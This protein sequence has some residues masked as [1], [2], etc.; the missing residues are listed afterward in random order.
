VAEHVFT[1]GEIHCDGCEN[2]IRTSLGRLSGVRDVRPDQATNTV[3]IRYDA[4]QVD[5]DQI[6][7]HL[8]ELGYPPVAATP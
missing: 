2:T 4:D 8:D 6:A 3:K 7:A 5:A 1:V